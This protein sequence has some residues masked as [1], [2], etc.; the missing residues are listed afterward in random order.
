MKDF[1]SFIFFKDNA[2]YIYEGE[3]EPE[4]IIDYVS[5]ENF[6]KGKVHSTSLTR[7]IPENQ[8]RL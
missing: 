1:P 6:K 4:Q 7:S 3:I 8:Q 2:A 5:N